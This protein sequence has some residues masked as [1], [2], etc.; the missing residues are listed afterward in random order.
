[1]EF[2]LSLA[3]PLKLSS[4]MINNFL[5]I[6]LLTYSVHLSLRAGIF[7]VAGVAFWALGG[8]LAANL[9]FA[10]QNAIVALAAA[11]VMSAV[12]G[13]L[14]GAILSKIRR[15]YLTMATFAFVLLVQVLVKSGGDYTGGQYGLFGVPTLLSTFSLVVLVALVAGLVFL[16]ECGVPGR[17]LEAMR[18]DEQLARA[19]GVNVAIWRAATFV[20]C[21]ALGGLAGAA[22]TLQIGLATPEA[23]SFSVIIEV[24]TIVVV[25]GTG[26]WYGPLMGAFVILWLPEVLSFSGE[27]RTIVQ[28]LVVVLIVVF[29]P[30]GF[31]GLVQRLASMV[32]RRRASNDGAA[33]QLGATS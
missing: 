6:S 7:S 1:M 14:L 28:G 26:A 3:G 15:L 19:M 17:T 11:T 16:L 21:A 24:L 30:N 27:W 31:V 22:N 5:A 13:A 33:S 32:S 12:L 29:M 8:Y 23:A 25:G 20:L 4:G 9:A 18:V 2:F 10:G